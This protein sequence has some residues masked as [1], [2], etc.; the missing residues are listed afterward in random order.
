MVPSVRSGDDRG[1]DLNFLVL[2]PLL[3]VLCL[4]GASAA[5]AH[6]ASHTL[7]TAGQVGYS[8][9]AA[10]LLL[11]G[12]VAAAGALYLFIFWMAFAS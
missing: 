1:M 12:V 10:V 5:G 6:A 2:V 7:D 4:G 3:T 11:A 9:L 8:I